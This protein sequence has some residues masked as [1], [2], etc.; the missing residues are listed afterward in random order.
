MWTWKW[1]EKGELV[2]QK[3][4]TEGILII[5][6]HQTFLA[7]LQRKKGQYTERSSLLYGGD[8][9]GGGGEAVKR[10]TGKAFQSPLKTWQQQW[11]TG[12]EKDNK[13]MMS[14]KHEYKQ[15]TIMQLSRGT[16]HVTGQNELVVTGHLSKSG[17]WVPRNATRCSLLLLLHPVTTEELSSRNWCIHFPSA[18]PDFR[19]S[20]KQ[21]KRK[22]EE[23]K[24]ESNN[25][26]SGALD[27]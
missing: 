24:K 2:S 1:K 3:K 25:I 12:E 6:K 19:E 27:T 11:R 5:C 10:R 8:G 4:N 20:K 18:I 17:K 26:S 15:G 9:D 23:E 16:R 13:L 22:K 14:F 21:N 7:P